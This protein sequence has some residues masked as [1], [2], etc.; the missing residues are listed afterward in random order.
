MTQTMTQTV[1]RA[2]SQ[3]SHVAY[4]GGMP[5]RVPTDSVAVRGDD[6]LA[7]A[8]VCDGAPRTQVVVIGP[9]GSVRG[10]CRT[11]RTLGLTLAEVSAEAL[12]AFEAGRS[13]GRLRGADGPA[14]DDRCEAVSVERYGC[15]PLAIAF[16]C[17]AMLE[18]HRGRA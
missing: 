13:F 16:A 10:M 9:D 18:T 17:G 12:F 5:V 6:L 1:V 11:W 4:I 7:L 8:L 15:G 2:Q 3:G 14:S